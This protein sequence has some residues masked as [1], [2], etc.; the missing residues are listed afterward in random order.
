[1]IGDKH[2]LDILLENKFNVV[3]IFSLNTVSEEMPTQA[4]TCPAR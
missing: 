1:M 3:A 2:L 4:N